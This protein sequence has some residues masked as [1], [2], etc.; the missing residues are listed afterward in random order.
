MY[1]IHFINIRYHWCSCKKL[2][3]SSN[4]KVLRHSWYSWIPTRLL[5]SFQSQR[6]WGRVG[7]PML[8]SD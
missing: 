1:F 7:T 4:N 2:V 8:N 6:S 5:C 3:S